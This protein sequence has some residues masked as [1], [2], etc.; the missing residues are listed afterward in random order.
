VVTTFVGGIDA[1]TGAFAD[2]IGTRAG[3]NYPW[4]LTVDVSGNLV[5][6]D[7]GNRRIRMVSPAGVVTTIA[8]G[9]AAVYS[10]AT[11]SLAGFWEPHGVAVDSIG[12]IVVA[13][14]YSNRIRRVTLAAAVTTIAGSGTYSYTDGIGTSAGFRYPAG[15]SVDANSGNIIATDRDNHC[16]RILTPPAGTPIINTLVWHPQTAVFFGIRALA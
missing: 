12:N 14:F 11:G 5:V 9:A 10:D 16:I 1:P 3:F 4:G 13:D 8:G 6:A 7:S 2:A 15:M